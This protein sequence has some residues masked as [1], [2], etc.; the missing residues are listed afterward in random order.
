MTLF[1]RR[2]PDSVSNPEKAS[3]AM[4]VSVIFFLLFFFFS[5]LLFF[6]EQLDWK[7]SHFSFFN[8]FP[9]LAEHL[10]R[11]FFLHGNTRSD[12]GPPT[13]PNFPPELWEANENPPIFITSPTSSTAPSRFPSMSLITASMHN[14]HSMSPSSSDSRPRKEY[15]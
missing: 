5:S 8:S 15:R 4:D 6:P 7:W 1:P 13:V 14:L 12:N 2:I 11:H 10:T 3:S 9:P